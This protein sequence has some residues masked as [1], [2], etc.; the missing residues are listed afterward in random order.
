MLSDILIFPFYFHI[1]DVNIVK[2]PPSIFQMRK[3][4]FRG[5]K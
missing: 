5:V 3:Q 4:Y 2:I 1:G